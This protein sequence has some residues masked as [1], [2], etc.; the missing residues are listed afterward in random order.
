MAAG[1]LAALNKYFEGASNLDRSIVICGSKLAP[2]M[3][4]RKIEGQ[5]PKS[6]HIRAPAVFFDALENAALKKMMSQAEYI[7]RATL[8]K[9]K[10]DG[11]DWEN[12]S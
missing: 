2:E 11:F 12:R 9:M 4:L 3:T 1:K 6:I 8:E 5:G 7:R 10:R